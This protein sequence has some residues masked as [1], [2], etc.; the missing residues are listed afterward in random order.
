M[1][2]NVDYVMKSDELRVGAQE[3][4]ARAVMTAQMLLDR[5]MVV[6]RTARGGRKAH[7]IELHAR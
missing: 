6:D 3:L 5:Q 7:H 1:E 4:A 2:K